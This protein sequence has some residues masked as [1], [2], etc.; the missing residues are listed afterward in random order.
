MR[1]YEDLKGLQ[2]RAGTVQAVVAFC[3]VALVVYFWHLQVVRG[4]YFRE[5]SE[6]NRMRAI[7]IP[8]PRGPLFDRNGQRLA[9]NR[10]SFN[11]VLITERR[12]DLD[13]ALSRIASFIDF[14]RD[15]VE[16]RRKEQGPKFRAL[17]V[18][19]DASA[20]DV[21]V[22][23]ARRLEEPEA[24][25][26]VVPV[27]SYPLG[28]GAA[29]V[30]GHVGEVTDKQRE[31]PAFA[32]IEPGTVVG[33][34][35]LELRYNRELMGTDGLRRIIV[36]S[37]GVEVME[38]ERVAPIDGPNAVLAIDLDLQRAFEEAMAGQSGSVIAMEPET[39]EILA[40][41][42]TPAYDPNEFSAGIQTAAWERLMSDPEKPLINRVIQGQYAPGSTFKIVS[43]LA[44]LQEGVITPAT[45]FHC[46]GHLAVYGT[47]FRC[48]KPG[49]HGTV[50]LKE[51]LALSCNVYFYN[52][53]IRL[54][55][56]RLSR[57]AKML[58]LARPTGIDLPHEL[59]GIFQDPEW[60]MRAQKVRWFPA[61]TVS[62]SIGQAMAVTPI[63]LAR[64]AAVVASGGRLPHPHLMKSIA[65]KP[66]ITVKPPEALPF[67]PGVL[68]TVRE[69]ML[70]VVQEGTGQRAR[71]AGIDVGG[72]TGSAQVVTHARLE[73]NKT[74]RAYQ[75]HGWFM[76]FAPPAHGKPGI[77]LAVL[78]EHGVGGGIS[79][80]PVVGKALARYYGV[81]AIGPGMTP[82]PDVLPADPS[83][84]R[85]QAA[86]RPAP[87]M[88]SN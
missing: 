65:G 54:E 25:V 56:E 63:Q 79:A 12:A 46:P 23:E 86:P 33:Q 38:T 31:Q 36:N 45:R 75:P 60:K 50:E 15:E 14:A 43:A 29:H 4:R 68:A 3:M 81:D 78:V 16:D 40:Y 8:A 32:N 42:S 53:G 18:K 58:G 26:E 57:Y 59:S 41:L 22:V 55:I 66:P 5:L 71:L 62:V 35:G 51:A 47:M 74:A 72:K 27:R 37:R 1:I 80:A 13:Q 2:R 28:T 61:E 88:G 85:A 7:A 69:A 34:A 52:V 11:V 20:E 76:A 30:I 87:R 19:A 77:A 24:S 9:E 48:H 83:P 39:G 17:V 84:V 82:P 21:A 67:R 6:N 49:G 10:S 73:S 64:I 70:A 44:A